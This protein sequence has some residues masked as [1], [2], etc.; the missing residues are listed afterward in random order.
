MKAWQQNVLL[1]LRTVAH[2][3]R[4][5]DQQKHVLD[6]ADRG[7]KLYDKFAGF[8]EDLQAVGDSLGKARKSWEMPRQ[9]FTPV[10][11]IL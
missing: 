7:G 2:V 5:A 10:R 1:T 11:A 8:V 6:I 9:N 3:W 4:L